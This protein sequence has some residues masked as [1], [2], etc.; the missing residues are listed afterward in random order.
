[1]ACSY[2]SDLYIDVL[3]DVTLR[4]RVHVVLLCT[5]PHV[6]STSKHAAR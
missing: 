2:M 3:M 5:G 4:V 1:M 6:Y